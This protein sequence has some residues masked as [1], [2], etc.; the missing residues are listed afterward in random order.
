MSLTHFGDKL[1]AISGIAQMV[2]SRLEDEYLA[3]MWRRDLLY[4]LGWFVYSDATRPS[5]YRAPSWSFL[6][7]DGHVSCI[8]GRDETD[9]A[10]AEVVDVHIEYITE[11]ETGDIRKGW[12]DLK[13]SLRPVRVQR[14]L[15]DWDAEELEM[16]FVKELQW[17]V[18]LGH[19]AAGDPF[20]CDGRIDDSSLDDDVI[21][22]QSAAGRH[23][24]ILTVRSELEFEFED[25]T[26]YHYLILR[27]VDG[28]N[29]YERVGMISTPHDPLQ[30]LDEELK[31]SLPC[32]RYEDGKH[33]IRII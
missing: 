24:C 26:Y 13:G 17:Q 6:S 31:R 21:L 1:V 9:I 19:D 10:E 18:E 4:D 25:K 27:L 14:F 32:I 2:R 22:R 29:E 15:M 23:F 28:T 7:V 11:D 12:L 30:D 3:G 16:G 8:K 5:T 33:T 20:T